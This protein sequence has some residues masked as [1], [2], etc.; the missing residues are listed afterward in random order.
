M[1]GYNTI[2]INIG[3]QAIGFIGLVTLLRALPIGPRRVL[4]ALVM[5]PSFTLWSSIA[6]KEALVVGFLGVV[7]AQVVKAY[8][9]ERI[10]YLLGL[11]S[12]LLLA[13]FKL[14]FMVPLTYIVTVTFIAKYVR[15]KSFVVL[16]ALLFSFLLLIIFGERIDELA[17]WVDYALV[18]MG[19]NS[20]RAPY[21]VE[22][23]DT[24]FK[25]PYGM[26][27]ALMGP[28]FSEASKGLLHLV[29][30][31]ESVL[32]FSILGY[33]MLRHL[34]TLPLYNFVLVAGVILW[35]LF[36]NYPL[37]VS[38]PGTAIRYRTDWIL[39]L[40]VG[41]V[42]LLPRDRYI[43]WIRGKRMPPRH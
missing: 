39:F 9:H 19:G 40:L 5:L 25:A 28:T 30:F 2:I 32:L 8:R 6:A 34:P 24:F 43:E 18:S 33:F 7:L 23:W 38:N 21:L 20:V 15:Q 16:T 3:F 35:T 22:K 1:S 17:R 36:P 29:A 10:N 41:V 26:F 14:H 31:T 27:L 13:V 37:A 12:L 42:F 4:F 11:P